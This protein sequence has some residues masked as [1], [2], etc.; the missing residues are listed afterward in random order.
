MIKENDFIL[1]MVDLRAWGFRSFRLL[2]FFF[3]GWWKWISEKIKMNTAKKGEREIIVNVM[4]S[5]KSR[6]DGF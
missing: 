5:E 1:N 2:F 6:G 4:F 3:F